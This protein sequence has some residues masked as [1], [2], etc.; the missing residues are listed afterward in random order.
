MLIIVRRRIRIG[1]VVVVVVGG[2]VDRWDSLAW[3]FM[4]AVTVTIAIIIGGGGGDTILMV[5]L[6]SSIRAEDT[7]KVLQ[8]RI[9]IEA[10]HTIMML[11]PRSPTQISVEAAIQLQVVETVR[12]DLQNGANVVSIK[13]TKHHP[14]DQGVQGV[15]ARQQVDNP[16]VTVDPALPAAGPGHP[17]TAKRATNGGGVFENG[18]D[19][20]N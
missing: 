15:A 17:R 7:I 19:G 13:N 1:V 14:K 4:M 5:V 2:A 16:E 6:P 12:S 20:L 11:D 10:V 8:N 9:Q 18:N 3:G